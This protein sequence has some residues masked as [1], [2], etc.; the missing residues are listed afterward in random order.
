MITNERE[1]RHSIGTVCKMYRLSEHEAGE[2][3]WDEETRTEIAQDTEATISNI[4]R[5]IAEYLARKYGF[6]THGAEQ[7]EKAA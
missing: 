2:T 4:E 7:A 1:L 6:I 5:E 3:L